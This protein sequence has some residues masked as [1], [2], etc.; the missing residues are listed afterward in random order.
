LKGKL[1]PTNNVTI[2][3]SQNESIR[4]VLDRIDRG[5]RRFIQSGLAAPV[6]AALGGVS[7]NGLINSLWATPIPPSVGFDGIGFES[8]PPSLATLDPATGAIVRPVVDRVTV[9][10]GYE[11]QLLASWGDPILSGAPGWAPDASQ[12]AGV[13]AQQFGMNNDGMHYFPMV[14]NG[15]ASSSRGLLC[16]NHEYTHESILHPDGLDELSG[17][18]PRSVATIQKIRKSQAAHGITVMEIRQ[19]SRGKWE[20]VKNSPYARRITANTPMKLSG[21]AAGHAL[22]RTKVYDIQAS[23]SVDTGLTTNGTVARGTANNCAHGYTPWGTY[24]TCEENWNGYFGWKNPAHVQTKLEQRYGVTKD[25]FTTTIAPHPTTS[26]YKWHL[27]DDRFDTDRTPNEPNT[28][29]WI[30]DRSIRSHECA[31]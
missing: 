17:G 12:D 18:L 19:V 22:L 6:L 20:V 3:T 28:F 1:H 8:I 10:P 13:Q 21:P 30:K 25:G 11:V 16:V 29:G 2:N 31:R 7:I 27:L 26:I 23:A 5:R 14:E 4:H 24:L 9:P 15:Q